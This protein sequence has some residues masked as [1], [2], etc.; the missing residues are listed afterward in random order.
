MMTESAVQDQLEGY[1]ARLGAS[2]QQVAGTVSPELFTRSLAGLTLRIQCS[3]P[4]FAQLLTRSLN[5]LPAVDP[6]QPASLEIFAW[7]IAA[8]GVP[9]PVPPWS[10]PAGTKE[11]RFVLPKGGEA[12][13]LQ[14]FEQG[15]LYILHSLVRQQVYCWTPDARALPTYLHAS[16]LLSPLHWWASS[17]GLNILHAG[18]VGTEEGAALLAGP[19]GSGKSTTALLSALEGLDYLSDDYSLVKL[20]PAPVAYC[21][22]SSGKLHRNHLQRFPELASRSLDPGPDR[23]EKPV[24]FMHEHFP[25]QVATSRP[26]RAVLAPRVTGQPDTRLVPMPAAEALRALAPSTLFQLPLEGSGNLRPMASLVR[27]L[28]CYRLDLGTD[29]SQIPR[30]IRQLLASQH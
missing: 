6:V 19:G 7:D 5:H 28:P 13:R 18:C 1:F 8:T 2:F 27:A 11:V 20:E 26:L 10:W 14:V 15:A 25:G 3:G 17:V 12:F 9:A 29:L 16:P 21:L 4:N 24:I 30:T 23:H 22:Y